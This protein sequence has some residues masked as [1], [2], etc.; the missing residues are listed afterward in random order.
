M[1][2]G[3]GAALTQHVELCVFGLLPR[4]IGSDTRV[5]AGTGQIGLGDPQEA[6]IWGHLIGVSNNQGLA[7]FEPCDLWWWVTFMKRRQI[8]QQA[9]TRWAQGLEVAL[10]S[11][12]VE[13]P[14][15]FCM[16]SRTAWPFLLEFSCLTGD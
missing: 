7:I 11:T 12:D 1:V 14:S 3:G 5:V 4:R 2:A 10:T 8:I 16:H 15:L 9:Q 13:F 6:P